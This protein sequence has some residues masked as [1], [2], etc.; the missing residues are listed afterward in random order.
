M[1]TN[2]LRLVTF[3]QAK[4]LKQVGF[5]WENYRTYEFNGEVAVPISEY[6]YNNS[7]NRISAPTVALALK[8]FRDEKGF[9]YSIIKG[10]LSFEYSYSLLNGKQGKL[11]IRGYEAAESALLDELLTILEKEG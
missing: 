4:R 7:D 10:R 1:R 6:N 5:D 11:H 9:D 8:W 3:E 2:Q